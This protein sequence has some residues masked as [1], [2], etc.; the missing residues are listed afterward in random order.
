MKEEV[1]IERERG[2]EKGEFFFHRSKLFS[3]CFRSLSFVLS[4]S[5][6]AKKH[7]HFSSPSLTEEHQHQ[8]YNVRGVRVRLHELL[9]A[10]ELGAVVA[11]SDEQD[12]ACFGFFRGF[13]CSPFP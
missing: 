8:V 11:E 10:Q 13:F 12:A 9:G 6:S 7:S 4:L 2:K 5:F 1:W 3:S